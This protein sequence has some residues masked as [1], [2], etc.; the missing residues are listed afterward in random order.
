MLE[1]LDQ[2]QSYAA[3]KDLESYDG[4]FRLLHAS[5]LSHNYLYP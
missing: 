2:S 1:N 3:R 5:P 4:S